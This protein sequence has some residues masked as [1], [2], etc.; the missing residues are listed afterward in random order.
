MKNTLTVKSTTKIL[1]KKFDQ[2]KSPV[3]Q[4]L[5]QFPKAIDYIARVSEYG[6]GKYGS[7]EEI[8]WDN[9]KKVDNAKF[10]YEQ[11]CGRHL[12]HRGLDES[13]FHSMAHTAWNALAVL[14]LT[15]DE[16]NI[17]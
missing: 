2:G 17:R 8:E 5:R 3:T 4:L 13:G 7:D 12:L 9:W 1:G 10:R 11:A 16:D 6:H 15:L 14:E